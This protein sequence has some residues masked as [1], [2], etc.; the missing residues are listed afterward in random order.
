MI[1]LPQLETITP[2]K[3]TNT[4]IEKE[5]KHENLFSG[6]NNS[7]ETG[8]HDSLVSSNDIDSINK[9]ANLNIKEGENS[10]CLQEHHI[11][12]TFCVDEIHDLI[13]EGSSKDESIELE[14]DDME[15]NTEHVK[16]NV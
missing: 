13:N 16:W 2:K 6:K 9:I 3:N 8:L 12:N 15:D 14:V 7:N 1:D 5:A 10:E 11:A 4:S